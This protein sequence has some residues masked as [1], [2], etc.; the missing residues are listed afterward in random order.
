MY[1]FHVT[2]FL[3]NAYAQSVTFPQTKQPGIAKVT[4]K[5][6]EYTLSND[7]LSAKF[8]NLDGKLMFVGS[9]ELGLLSDTE[10]FK[11]RLGDG[12][13]VPA[14]AMKL[15]KVCIIKLK[16]NKNAVKGVKRFNGQA[17]EAKFE[18]KE[19]NIIWRAVLR[20]GSHYLRTEMDI[21]TDKD[22]AMHS[23]IPMLYNV[24]NQ[25]GTVVPEV[26]GNTRGAVI[27]S[28]RIFAG[29]ETPTG[30]NTS[31]NIQT[32]EDNWIP[33]KTTGMDM[34][35]QNKIGSNEMLT[36]TWTPTDWKISENTPKRINELGFYSNDVNNIVLNLEV[37]TPGVLSTEFLYK[38]GNCGLSIV[39]MDL[40]E[41][42]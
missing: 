4:E 18:Y 23:I 20:D 8:I 24:D 15:E 3:H 2:I 34:T 17:I 39:G 19:L 21:T 5:K 32:C 10:I 25:N 29:L 27:A 14:S 6:G 31:G 42:S 26:I 33:V 36:G 35:W 38:S 16:G 37:G 28:N 22:I 1:G 13:E 9:S 41:T 11:I 40:L 30:I 7:L 12:T